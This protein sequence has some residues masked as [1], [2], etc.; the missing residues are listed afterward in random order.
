[1]KLHELTQ[2]QKMSILGIDEDSDK[3]TFTTVAV[4]SFCEGAVSLA[5]DKR[6]FGEESGGWIQDKEL[7][8]EVSLVHY[9][10]NLKQWGKRVA[11]REFVP[12][13]CI[14]ECP[15]T[16]GRHRIEETDDDGISKQFTCADCGKRVRRG[17]R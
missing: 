14:C 1:M 7:A 17:Y 15:E 16:G 9:G 5:V 3:V 8:Y 2:E 12:S 13:P 10:H 6:V 11:N 4:C